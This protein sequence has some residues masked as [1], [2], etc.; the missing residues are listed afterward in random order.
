MRIYITILFLL[1][2]LLSYSQ[3]TTLTIKKG[4]QI[5]GLYYCKINEGKY[6]YLKFEGDSVSKWQTNQK[7]KNLIKL[8]YADFVKSKYETTNYTITDSLLVFTF[9]KVLKNG[10]YIFEDFHCILDKPKQLYIK[11]GSSINTVQIQIYTLI[12]PKNKK[13]LF[14]KKQ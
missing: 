10:S 4:K 9:K 5:S 11:K 14:L 13:K 12:E 1:S 2:T 3:N 6:H 7:H 8:S